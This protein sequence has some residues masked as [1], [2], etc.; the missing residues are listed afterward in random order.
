MCSEEVD[1][2]MEPITEF[3][4]ESYMATIKEEPAD[5][6]SNRFTYSSPLLETSIPM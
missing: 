5:D 2:K 6:V 4:A 1:V 3:E